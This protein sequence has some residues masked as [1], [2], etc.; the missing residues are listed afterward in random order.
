M[1]ALGRE[2]NGEIAK[3]LLPHGVDGNATTNDGHTALMRA[4][5]GGHQEIVNLLLST[6]ANVNATT[7]FGYTALILASE[8]GYTEIVNQLIAHGADVN[9]QEA[10]G[11][12]SLIFASEKGHGEVVD[13]LLSNGANVN[14]KTSGS[15]TSLFRASQNGH[16]ETVN[17]LLSFGANVNAKTNGGQTAL[18]HASQYGHAETVSLLL[19]NGADVNA[20]NARGQTALMRASEKGHSEIVV[21]LSP[22]FGAQVTGEFRDV[23]FWETAGGNNTIFAAGSGTLWNERNEIIAEGDLSVVDEALSINGKKEASFL[24]TASETAF[25]DDAFS[26]QDV[27]EFATLELSEGSR[28]TLQGDNFRFVLESP[29]L[30]STQLLISLEKSLARASIITLPKGSVSLWG[31]TI[32]VENEK[33]T[34]T[35]AHGKVIESSGATYAQTPDVMVETSY[36]LETEG[37]PLVMR[38]GQFLPG[39]TTIVTGGFTLTVIVDGVKSDFSTEIIGTN[40]DS[41]R[42]AYRCTNG[43]SYYLDGQTPRPFILNEFGTGD[44]DLMTAVAAFRSDETDAAAWTIWRYL[45]RKK[46]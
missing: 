34:V 24:Y 38:N 4:S 6:G 19:S 17:A 9:A 13:L 18:I 22:N 14:A 27:Q 32:T 33:G 46:E 39:P 3:V 30:M 25:T 15:I 28:W 40:D 41:G 7:T 35:F 43:E 45:D 36:G 16:T 29:T 1:H 26:D 2:D 31:Y 10:D 21:L 23:S 8:G 44:Q 11:A 20:K 5:G 12:T 37:G 42:T